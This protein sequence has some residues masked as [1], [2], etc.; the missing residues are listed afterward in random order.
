MII[1]IIITAQMSRTRTRTIVKRVISPPHAFTA[2]TVFGITGVGI[3]YTMVNPLVAVLGAVNI[4]IYT[5]AYTPLKRISVANTWAGAVVGG[6][7]PLMGWVA[8]TQSIDP[9][10]IVMAMSLYAWQ[11][12]HFNALSWNLRPDYSKAGYR[13]M[14]TPIIKL[15]FIYYS[16]L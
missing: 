11:F 12:P 1:I 8:V 7:P 10:A 6:I 4:V 16:P 5:C 2:G 9:G 3:L 13:M 15:M 14:V